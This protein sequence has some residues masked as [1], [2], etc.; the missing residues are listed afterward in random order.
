MQF[1]PD[2]VAA[3]REITRVLAPGGWVVTATGTEIT[4]NPFNQAFSEVI[5]RHLGTLALHTTISLGTRNS[6]MRTSSTL[7]SM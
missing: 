1:F 4:N 3:Q 7:D 6:C 5:E 2:K